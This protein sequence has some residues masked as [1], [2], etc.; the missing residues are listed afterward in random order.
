MKPAFLL[1]LLLTTLILQGCA[2]TAARHDNRVDRR[3][4]RRTDRLSDR[5]ERID[6]RYNN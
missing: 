5:Q 4:D 1:L 2:G 3:V 6:S